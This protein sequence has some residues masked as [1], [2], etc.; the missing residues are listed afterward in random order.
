MSKWQIKHFGK[1]VD[2][3]GSVFIERILS[4]YSLEYQIIIQYAR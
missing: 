1:Q 2:N 3:K 4:Y